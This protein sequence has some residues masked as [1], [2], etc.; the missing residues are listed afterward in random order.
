MDY[1]GSNI[2]NAEIEELLSGQC[3]ISK[4]T[5]MEIVSVIGKYARGG[6]G[7]TQVCSRVDPSTGVMCERKYIIPKKAR[8][9]TSKVKAWMK[10]IKEVS[11]GENKMLQISILEIDDSVML[12]AEKFIQHALR[13]N[14]KSMDAIILGTAKANSTA[15]DQMIVVT[16]DKGLKAGIQKIQY[17]HI[18][19]SF[20]RKC[21]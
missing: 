8:W 4:A 11:S 6:G 12:E 9:S 15:D 13:Y 2:K 5:Q 3:Y 18:T 10:L 1:I 16:A 17:P 7:E 21:S 19:V 20:S 14:F